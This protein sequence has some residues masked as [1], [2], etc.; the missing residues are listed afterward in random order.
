MPLPVI[1]WRKVS[2]SRSGWLRVPPLDEESTVAETTLAASSRSRRTPARLSTRART[3]SR[4]A[5]EASAASRMIVSITSVTTLP[6]DTTR[7]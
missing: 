4:P 1:V 5:S 6:L 7:S 3:R 2:K